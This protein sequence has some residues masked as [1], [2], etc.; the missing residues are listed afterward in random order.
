MELQSYFDNCSFSGASAIVIPNQSLYTIFFT[1]CAFI[2]QAFTNSQPVGN[3]T[4]TVFTDCS[5][6]PS[7]SSLNNCILNGLNTTLTSTQ[8]NY[9]SLVLGGSATSLLKGNGT[10]LSGAGFVKGDATLDTN[11]YVQS[12]NNLVYG[13]RVFSKATTFQQ[14]AT[15]SNTDILGAVSA[16][17]VLSTTANSVSVGDTFELKMFLSFVYP[18][19]ANAQTPTF[20]MFGSSINGLGGFY[21]IGA[22]TALYTNKFVI[23]SV[24]ASGTYSGYATLN[25]QGA[26]YTGQV[27]TLSGSINTSI[28]QPITLTWTTAGNTTLTIYSCELM[29]Y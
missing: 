8:G 28:S 25:G 11:T 10:T 27:N 6:L 13:G 17:G 24:G 9:G 18:T 4:K 22:G 12:L 19:A 3:T 5:Y 14:T 26:A 7:L 2:G 29:R 20:S 16:G 23:R 1:R 21:N 15:F